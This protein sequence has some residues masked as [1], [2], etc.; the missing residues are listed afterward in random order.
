MKYTG[1]ALLL[2]V[3]CTQ[4]AL[5]RPM[6]CSKAAG[7]LEH[8]ICADPRLTSAD[9]EMGKAYSAMLKSTIDTEIRAVLLASQRRWIAARDKHFGEL[10]DSVDARTGQVYTQE[11]QRTLLLKAI[12]ERTRQLNRKSDD[13]PLEPHLVQQAVKQ[14]ALAARFT[15]GPFSGSTVSCEFVPHSGDFS[16]GCFGSRFYQNNRRVCSLSQDWASGDLYEVQ[17]VAD[18]INGKPK[19]SATCKPGGVDCAQGSSAWSKQPA[20]L[21]ADTQR[22]YERL[23]DKSLTRLDVDLEE[24]DDVQ[25]LE[26]CLND[27]GFPE[28]GAAQ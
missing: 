21:D 13:A 27:P 24:Q 22:V 14:R 16:Y 9:A 1:L 23:S 20:E 8:L 11:A 12:Q 5:A 15:G 19:L 17:A 7:D 4:S 10:H 25:W 2:A 18:V 28:L 26:K 6:D 3:L